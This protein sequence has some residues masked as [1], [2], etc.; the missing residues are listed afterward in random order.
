MRVVL[1]AAMLLV[2]SMSFPHAAAPERSAATLFERGQQGGIVLPVMLNGRGPFRF[3]LDTGST[4][5][6]VSAVTAADVGAP[7]VAKASMGSVA[8]SRE[9]L[10]VR[11]D[12]VEFGAIRVGELLASVVDLDGIVDTHGIDG[13]IGLDVLAPLRYTIDFRQRRIVWWPTD[14]LVA[15]GRPLE[16]QSR[17]GRFLIALPQGRALVRL[18]PDTGA[19]SLLL[20]DPGHALP[21]T[22]LRTPATLTTTSGATEVQL[23]RVRELR[24]GSL[25]LRDI[26][27]VVVRRD[28]SEP[29]E[30]DGLL[31]LHLFD[32]VTVDG[33]GKRM[34]VEKAQ[35]SRGLMFF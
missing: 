1:V 27:A 17:H 33:P 24:V 18:V 31:P 12:A 6:A 7:V 13:V 9:R 3:L 22:D 15:R 14:A 34:I 32:R 30:V 26:P 21:V 16:L 29:A 8:G 19:E 5:T 10:V 4:H 11:I 28:D 23:A 20:F 35:E 25:T 2:G